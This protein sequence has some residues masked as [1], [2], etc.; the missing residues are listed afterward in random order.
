MVDVVVP[1][2]DRPDLTE[3]C[4]T[5]VRATAPRARL[6]VV[7][8]GSAVPVTYDADVT[9]RHATNRGFAAGC[10]AGA[11][12]AATGTLVFLNNDTIPQPGWLDPLVDAVDHGHVAQPR[13]VYPDGTVQ[14]A[15][16]DL[17]VHGGV[18]TAVNRSTDDPSGPRAAL[19]GACLAISTMAFRTIGGFDERYWNGYEDVDLCLRARRAGWTCWY[20]ASATVVHLE[21]QSGPARWTHVAHNIRLLHDTWIGTWQQLPTS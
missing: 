11:A 12:L 5:A 18:L 9:I 14:C 10:N 2:Y 13:L 8:N 16:V 7:D 3:A 15:G 1:T 21:S 20:E 4:L 17:A 6:I 19:T